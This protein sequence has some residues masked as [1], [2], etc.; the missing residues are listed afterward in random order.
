MK[1][2]T[3]KF[4][5]T[6]HQPSLW[7][8]AD[9]LKVRA[10]DPTTTQ[11]LVSADFPVLN[12]DVFIWDT[13]PLRDLDGNVTSVDGWSVI[14]TLTAD[15][16]PNDPAY[17]D[18]DGNYDILRDWN[19]RHGRAKMYYW[20]SRTGK[21]WEFGGRVMAEG[22]SPTAR[23]WAGTPILLNDRGEVDLYYT[24][25]TPGATIVKVRGRVVTT[26]HGVSMV[27][28][29]KVKPLFEADGKMYQTEAQNAF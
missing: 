19:D 10:D 14:F 6:P 1:T 12:N 17:L 8:R 27:G 2:T 5:V 22:V 29:E 26:E 9:A 24:A 20:F 18:E 21:N 13:M 7:T 16:H 15:R 4:G 28:F 23:E 11:P 25:V 3:E